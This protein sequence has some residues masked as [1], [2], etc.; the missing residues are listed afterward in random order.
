[1]RALRRAIAILAAGA[2]LACGAPAVAAA[3]PGLGAAVS[4][5][6]SYSSGE[7]SGPPFDA[8][9]DVAGNRCHRTPLAWPRLLGVPMDRHLACSG[10]TL[11]GL[12]AGTGLPPD[13]RGQLARLAEL[14]AAPTPVLVTIG[15]NDAG[16]AD[17][18]RR[19]VLGSCVSSIAA[20]SAAL[21]GLGARLEAAYREIAA[22]SR[23]GRVLVVGYPEILPERPPRGLRCI[24][25]GDAEV[26]AALRFTGELNATIAA[27][28]ERAGVG[29]A[30]IGDALDGHELCTDDSWMFPVVLNPFA[31]SP[32]QA[33]PRAPGQAA[34]AAAVAAHLGGAPAPGGV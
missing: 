29:F 8:G 25:L 18:L 16:F 9:T 5:G 6:D 23:G 30:P 24:W 2:L 22:A 11:A 19:C 15:G 13:D 26:P 28:A 21:P 14:A 3:A 31:V 1:M 12:A 34:M 17:I 10:A 7:G 27:A 4:L 20:R 32:Q 33:H